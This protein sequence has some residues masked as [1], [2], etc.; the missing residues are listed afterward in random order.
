MKKL[1]LLLTILL[2]FV[3]V[4][5]CSVEPSSSGEEQAIDTSA[6][7]AVESV[8]STPTAAPTP[9]P[10][11]PTAVPTPSPSPTP[12]PDWVTVFVAFENYHEGELA[13]ITDALD[14]AGYRAVITS[15]ETGTAKGM[16]GGRLEV[17]I[18]IE[19][20]EDIGL[21]IVIAGGTGVVD[22][23]DNEVLLGLVRNA[24]DQVLL[25]AG[26]CA[27]PGVLGN[28]GVLQGKSASWYDGPNTNAAM[29]DAGCTNS[30]QAVTI[31]GNAVTGNEP[32]AATKFGE[33]IVEVLDSI[34]ADM[35]KY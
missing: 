13:G 24:N 15:T 29:R 12:K 18:A 3:A 33:A 6:T 30:G 19:E 25:V 22:I 4:P 31:D 32:S 26:I 14:E 28:A 7:T 2:C 27:G 23:W 11:T 34:V 16:G 9:V 21:G 10:P 35:G 20:I 5:A 1:I 17:D 8:S